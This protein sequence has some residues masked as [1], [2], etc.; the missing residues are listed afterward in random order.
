MITRVIKIKNC[1][2]FV[3]FVPGADLPA[4]RKYNLIYGWNG[5]GKTNFSRVLRS[6]ELRENYYAD[7]NNPTEFEFQLDNGTAIS[8]Q[9]LTVFPNIRV[10]NKDFI[11]ESVFCTGGPK[12]IFFLSKES[13]EDQEKIMQLG[14]QLRKLRE[15]LD[16]KR[17]LLDKAKIRKEKM[18]SDKARDI[19]TALTTSRS[20][21]YRNYERPNLE[22]A[23]QDNVNELKSNVDKYKLA[24]DRV[25]ILQKTIQQT[26]KPKVESLAFPDFDISET[27]SEVKKV[28]QTTVTS[29]II[30]SLKLDEMLNKWVEHGLSI[31]KERGLKNCAFCNQVIPHHRFSELEQHFND[32][33]QRLIEELSSLKQTLEGKKISISFPDASSFYD[34]LIEEYLNAKKEAEEIVKKFNQNID[35]L[36]SALVQK[37]QRPFSKVDLEEWK[38]VEIRPFENIN[39]IISKHNERS[40]NFDKQIDESKHILEMHYIADFIHSYFEQMDEIEKLEKEVSEL[41]NEIKTNETKENELKNSLISHRIPANRINEDL[42]H[43]LGRDDIRLVATDK[44]EGYQIFRN[45]TLAKD[46]SEAE[47]TALALVYFLTK[48]HEKGFDLKNGVIVMDDPVSSFDSNSIFQAFGFIKESIKEAKQIFILTHHFDFFRQVK[49]WFSYY[50]EDEREFFMMVCG[51]EDSV[52]KSRIATIDK[53]LIGYESEYHFLF[54]ILY[55]FAK[56]NEVQLENAYPIPNIAR[57]FLESFLAFRVPVLAN[58]R[59]KEPNLYH[60]LEKIDFDKKKKERILRFIETHSHPRY[61]S[62]VQDFDMTILGET[63]EI[64]NDLLALV[65]HED[66]KHFEFLVKS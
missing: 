62:G 59:Q 21:K 54:S 55:R 25:A 26:T 45:G 6:F 29:H 51:K 49:N 5:S 58:G 27:V 24:G 19:K 38:Q 28:L 36:I 52:R 22:K 15:D 8:Q 23:I 9:D 50:K 30:E 37:E 63:K 4:F 1:A 60:R 64:V 57:K 33:Y 40:D 39:I 7:L 42:K 3:D 32:D 65:E 56:N 66:K 11:N 48:I 46:L 12:P 18:L 17:A 44:E 53:L 20:D 35:S 41:E 61:E 13:K 14:N 16:F 34:D 43:F 10:F 47:K 2:S 31:H